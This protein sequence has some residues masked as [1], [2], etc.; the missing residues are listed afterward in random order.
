MPTVDEAQS[1]NSGAGALAAV[2][3]PKTRAARLCGRHR[4]TGV[5]QLAM[6]TAITAKCARM[7]HCSSTVQTPLILS[8]MMRAQ[9]AAG[10][11][12]LAVRP[13]AASGTR[14]AV[15]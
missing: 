11:R 4:S 2:P 8:M 6:L 10:A 9:E 14:G 5:P 3:W 13:D 7:N 1:H 15:S 12:C